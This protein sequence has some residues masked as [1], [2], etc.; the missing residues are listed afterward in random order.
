M[1]RDRRLL[2]RFWNCGDNQFIEY[3]M[4]RARINRTERRVLNL[5]F[6]ECLTQEEAAEVMEISTRR[7]QDIYYNAADKLLGIPWVTAYAIQLAKF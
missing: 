6:D 5:I 2:R 4:V 7:I 1:E 3:A